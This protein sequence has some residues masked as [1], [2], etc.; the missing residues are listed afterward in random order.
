MTK[1]YRLFVFVTQGL[2]RN[3]DEESMAAMFLVPSE[4]AEFSGVERLVDEEPF[5]VQ[6]QTEI[7]LEYFHVSTKFVLHCFYVTSS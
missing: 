6:N 2:V 3:G 5:Q 1:I 4:I 7:F